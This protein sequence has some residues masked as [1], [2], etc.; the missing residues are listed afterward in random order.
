M[1]ISIKY[2]FEISLDRY[3]CRL[4]TAVICTITVS[5]IICRDISTLSV[6]NFCAIPVTFF[7]DVLDPCR[8]LTAVLNTRIVY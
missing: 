3:P 6:I 5:F 1:W 2:G 4:L 8:L 7:I